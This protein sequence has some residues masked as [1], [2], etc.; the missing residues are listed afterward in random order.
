MLPEIFIK[1]LIWYSAF[2]TYCWDSY[3]EDFFFFFLQ[4]WEYNSIAKD[5]A[6]GLLNISFLV[7]LKSACHFV[8]KCHGMHLKVFSNQTG[9][10]TVA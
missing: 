10:N 9:K 2:L 4:A 8:F 6:Y 3:I 1:R 5:S 7:T